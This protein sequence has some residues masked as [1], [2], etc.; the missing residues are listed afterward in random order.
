MLMFGN[1][2]EFVAS[3][4][5]Y[6]LT[7][8]LCQFK[9][10]TTRAIWYKSYMKGTSKVDQVLTFLIHLLQLINQWLEVCAE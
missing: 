6:G 5:T 9:S 7:E 1:I 10:P 8:S 2:R 4:R 3:L